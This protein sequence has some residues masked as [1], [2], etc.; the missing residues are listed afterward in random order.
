MPWQIMPT[1]FMICTF[2]T[3]HF[4]LPQFP[5]LVSGVNIIDCF[6]VCFDG[7]THVKGS[8]KDLALE[9]QS[10]LVLLFYCASRVLYFLQT[11]GETLRQQKDYDLL[12]YD[13][14]FVAVVWN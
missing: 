14:R 11:E 5:Y 3:N 4:S 10:H 6:V 2:W 9:T 8:A 13:T 7:I 1:S 12:Y